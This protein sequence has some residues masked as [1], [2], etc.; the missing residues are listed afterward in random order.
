MKITKTINLIILLFL[1]L[2]LPTII[3]AQCAFDIEYLNTNYSGFAGATGQAVQGKDV[4]FSYNISR[5]GSVKIPTVYFYFD[6]GD[7]SEWILMANDVG[8]GTFKHNYSSPGQHNAKIYRCV[9]L[10]RQG[11]CY[12]VAQCS[13]QV[14]EKED[15]KGNGGGGGGGGSSIN[16]SKL[17]PLFYQKFGDLFDNIAGFLLYLS[18][19]LLVLG[20]I[21]GGFLMLNSG[22]LQN[23]EKGKKIILLAIGF[24]AIMLIIKLVTSFSAKDITFH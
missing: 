12:D 16:K 10:K 2:F 9:G 20:I 23:I 15:E 18:I 17:N 14:K 13:I 3:N 1:I 6:P 4:T 8:S 19:I 21:S 22:S 24:F 5:T 7:G 11:A